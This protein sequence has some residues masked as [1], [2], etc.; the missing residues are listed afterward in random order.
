MNSRFK[1]AEE[2]L[3]NALA[4]V[5]DAVS[6]AVS[7]DGSAS[8]IATLENENETLRERQ[9]EIASR[10]DTAI[11]RLQRVLGTQQ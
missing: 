2:R 7:G 9:G 8:R 6:Q 10:L 1:N 5:D 11:E 3:E 4:R